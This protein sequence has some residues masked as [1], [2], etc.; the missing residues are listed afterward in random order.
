MAGPWET[1]HNFGF[2][3]DFAIYENDTWSW[4]STGENERYWLRLRE[5]A[6]EQDLIV[7]KFSPNSVQLNVALT[8]LQ[9]GVYP[10]GGDAVWADNLVSMINAWPLDDKPVAPN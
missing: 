10:S 2:E 6:E 5:L 8:D 7:P 3:V 1:L 9:N 4:S